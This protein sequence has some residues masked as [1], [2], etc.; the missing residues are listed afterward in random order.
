MIPNCVLNTPCR[1]TNNPSDSE[2]WN[3]DAIVMGN[4]DS[5]SETRKISR[6]RSVTHAMRLSANTVYAASGI[7]GSSQRYWRIDVDSIDLFDHGDSDVVNFGV[8]KLSPKALPLRDSAVAKTREEGGSPVVALHL[9]N[10]RPARGCTRAQLVRKELLSF[11]RMNP[12]WEVTIG[13]TGARSKDAASCEFFVEDT[14]QGTVFLGPTS[15]LSDSGRCVPASVS[16][17]I[18]LVIRNEVSS[19]APDLQN[20]CVT[21]PGFLSRHLDLE[22]DL[23]QFVLSFLSSRFV[24]GRGLGHLAPSVRKVFR[25]RGTLSGTPLAADASHD[26]PGIGRVLWKLRKFEV[27]MNRVHKETVEEFLDYCC[28]LQT[29]TGC[30]SSHPHENMLKKF[31]RLPEVVVARF[32]SRGIDHAVAVD[33]PNTLIYDTAEPH[34][35]RLCLSSLGICAGM[36]VGVEKEM[37][38]RHIQEFRSIAKR[39]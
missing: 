24:E 28:F 26:R 12:G 29:R 16:I 30:S 21:S 6:R 14:W 13:G 20:R 7:S 37:L 18:L 9:Q 1:A 2:F 8:S 3:I 10:A 22:R 32:S 25:W 23:V 15:A 38:A 35:M 17:S 34:P 19:V 27:S 4:G 39:T 36:G 31:E 11:I 33:L 5:I